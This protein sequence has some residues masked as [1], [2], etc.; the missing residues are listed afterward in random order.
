MC[1]FYGSARPQKLAG[2]QEIIYA[3]IPQE[4]I[5]PELEAL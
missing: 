5:A 4:R 1:Y 2:L 3:V